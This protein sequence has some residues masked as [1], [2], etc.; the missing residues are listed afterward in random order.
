MDAITA[1][2]E[3]CITLLRNAGGWRRTGRIES[4]ARYMEQPNAADLPAAFVFL[5]GSDPKADNSS[6]ARIR[7]VLEVRIGVA[8][9]TGTARPGPELLQ[10][11][12]RA[13]QA[14][15]DALGGERPPTLEKQLLLG[16]GAQR[17]VTAGAVAYEQQF[18]SQLTVNFPRTIP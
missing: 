3:H 17:Q 13:R 11:N 2:L 1:A 8:I 4:L 10:D 15:I 6:T 16:P 9:I 18:I 7:Q 12:D 5:A 14:A